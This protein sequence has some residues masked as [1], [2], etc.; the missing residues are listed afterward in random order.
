MVAV[1]VVIIVTVVIVTL[2]VMGETIMVRALV[3]ITSTTR[4]VS[5]ISGRCD[6]NC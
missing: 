4:I 3:P 1:I 5:G 2:I 6:S